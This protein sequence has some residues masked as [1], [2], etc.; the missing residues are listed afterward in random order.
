MEGF[1]DFHLLVRIIVS[2]A[3][4][5]TEAADTGHFFNALDYIA[6][7]RVVN[8]CHHQTD[9]AGAPRLQALCNGVGRI[10]HLMCHALDALSHFEANERTAVEGPRDRRV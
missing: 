8:R 7:E 9:C 2:G 4:Q 1:N 3:E 6:E 5:D 10:T